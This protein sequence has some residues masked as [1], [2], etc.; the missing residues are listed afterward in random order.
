MKAG[1]PQAK[2]LYAKKELE[3][4]GQMEKCKS[5]IKKLEKEIDENQDIFND[6]RAISI[7]N[8]S[9]KMISLCVNI[10]DDMAFLRGVKNESYLNE[11]RKIFYNILLTLE[12]VFSD[13]INLEPTEIQ[14]VTEK[15]TKFDPARK[16]IFFRKMGFTLDRISQ[17][18]GEKSK[19]KWTFVD[20][21][22]RYAVLMKNSM[23]FKELLARDPRKD[24]FEEN[25]VLINIL[26]DL[27][28]KASDKLRE[29]YELA[30]KEVTDMNKAIKI[31]DELRRIYT[32]TNDNNAVDEVKKKMEVWTEKLEKDQQNKERSKA[33]NKTKGKKKKGF[34]S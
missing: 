11:G 25:E 1:S 32:L 31:L 7:A 30:T 15:M 23:N 29:K 26:F 4:K 27:L 33:I 12:K 21:F 34:F 28:N 18:F 9:L 13:F 22:S 14:A 3:F 5:F 16:V 8:E 10:T 17:A 20:M 19:Y 6:Y 24:F 2:A